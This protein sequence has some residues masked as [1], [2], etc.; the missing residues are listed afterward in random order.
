MNDPTKFRF[1]QQKNGWVTFHLTKDVTV[2][3]HVLQLLGSLAMASIMGLLYMISRTDVKQP[4]TPSMLFLSF[5]LLTSNK[6]APVSKTE[7]GTK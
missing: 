6:A 5:R 3:A 7:A 4:G 1:N 2:Y